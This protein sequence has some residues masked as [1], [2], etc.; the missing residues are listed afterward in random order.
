VEAVRQS[1]ADAE[2]ISPATQAAIQ[3][4]MSFGL[5]GINDDTLSARQLI[6]CAD[7]AAYQAKVEGRNRTQIFSPEMAE[8]LGIGRLGE[9]EINGV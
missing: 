2:F 1:V 7:M 5:A 6:H 3:A 4:T 8:S 9:I